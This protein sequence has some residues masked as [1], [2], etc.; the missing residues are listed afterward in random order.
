MKNMYW[1]SRKVSVI[2]A[3]FY[4]DFNY[5][6][7]F[8]KNTQISNFMKIRSVGAELFH[9]DAQAERHG[10]VKSLSAILR[11]RLIYA[12]YVRV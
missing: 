6:D 11:R 1:S 3:G 9:T 5:Q 4:P 12:H 2:L 10:D 8:S 7:I